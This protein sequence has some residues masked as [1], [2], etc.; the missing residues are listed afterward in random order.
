VY[1]RERRREPSTMSPICKILQS[2]S[3]S[4]LPSIEIDKK[5]HQ[6]GKKWGKK[7]YV[8]AAD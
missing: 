3:L 5:K 6:H 7:G 2:H 4:P 1:F 8:D